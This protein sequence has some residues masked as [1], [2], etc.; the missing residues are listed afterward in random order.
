MTRKDL[1]LIHSRKDNV[2]TS[3]GRVAAAWISI[4]RAWRL[5]FTAGAAVKARPWATNDAIVA[6]QANE[7]REL[8]RKKD[9]ACAA[10]NVLE[11]ATFLDI[12]LSNR[13]PC[14][15]HSLSPHSSLSAP[16]FLSETLA[17]LPSTSSAAPATA[18]TSIDTMPR[19]LAIAIFGPSHNSKIGWLTILGITLACPGER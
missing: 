9:R 5:A 15:A 14:S 3:A 17:L 1:H 8:K 19:H 12:D 7:A 11:A 18:R 2:L 4:L 10:I 13:F 16:P 6:M